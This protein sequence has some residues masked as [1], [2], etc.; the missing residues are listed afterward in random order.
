M[1]PIEE[2]KKPTIS[3]ENIS[4]QNC[5]YVERSAVFSDEEMELFRNCEWNHFTFGDCD[6]SLLSRNRLVR[7]LK[8]SREDFTSAIN[9]L[10]ELPS[11][12]FVAL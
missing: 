7:E 2:M 8:G 12:C 4:V 11:D 5:K 1:K 10:E 3:S 6:K 9:R